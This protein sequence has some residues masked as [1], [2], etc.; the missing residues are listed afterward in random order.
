MYQYQPQPVY[1]PEKDY[2]GEAFL[3]LVLYYF[4]LGI[5]GLIANI[6]FLNN[7]RRDERQ[8]ILT[9]NVGCLQALLWVHIVGM[10][11]GCIASVIFLVL[12]GF[13]MIVEGM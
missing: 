6:I 8:G 13:A 10:V 5:V 4:G 1:R 2:L 9:R 12:G 11:L 7:A 3:S